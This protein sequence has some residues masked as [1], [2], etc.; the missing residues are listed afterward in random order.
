M[1][2]FDRSGLG[3]RL[4]PLLLLTGACASVPQQSSLMKATGTEATAGEIRAADNALA[5]SIPGLIETS[6]DEIIARSSDPAVRRRALRWKIDATPAYY[7]ALFR[8]DPLVAAIDAWVL[9]IQIEDYLT[10]GPGKSRFGELQPVALDAARKIRANI[11]SQVKQVARR[12]E[13]FE[14]AQTQVET[15]ARENP[16]TESFSTRPSILVLLAKMS[17]PADS[18]VFGAVG[19][20]T[21]TVGDIATRLDIYSA[22]ILKAGRWQGELLVDEIAQRDDAKEALATMRSVKALSDRVDTLASPESIQDA[23]SF[24]VAAFRTERVAAMS[25]IDKM[26]VD[27]LAYL[28][29]EREIALASVNNERVAVMAEIDHQRILAMQQVDE[30]RKQTF[31]DIDRLANRVILRAALA[32]AAL[33][34]LAAALAFVVLATVRSRKPGTQTGA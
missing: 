10:D 9:S 5:V 17:G 1:P 6:S 15:W 27:S 22:Y 24:A 32:V 34:V 28:T 31:A 23:T 14:Q 20:I 7:L 30:L 25:S 2:T 8:S 3:Y 13:G 18:N 21:A 26:R 19:D 29:G 4:M 33:L 12:P 16:I 11:A